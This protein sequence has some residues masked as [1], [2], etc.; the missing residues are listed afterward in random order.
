M[1]NSIVSAENIWPTMLPF[2]VALGINPIDEVLDAHDI[3]QQ[4]WEAIQA[5]PS[6]RKSLMAAQKEVAETGL[7][8]QRKAA[9][10]AEMYL[11]DVDA[12]MT[13]IDTSP[14]LKVDIFK[15]MVKF[16]NLEPVAA[17][18]DAAG[19]STFNIQINI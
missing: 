14:S 13:S 18:A 8:F 17:K 4:E 2:E 5:N 3:D 15:A 9:I 1:S 11:E 16:G 12:L 6:F 19:N 7:S 10:Q